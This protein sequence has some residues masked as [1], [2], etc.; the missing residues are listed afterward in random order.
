MFTI[1]SC[2]AIIT[3]HVAP[4]Y[5]RE[6]KFLTYRYARNGYAERKGSAGHYKF[7]NVIIFMV[8]YRAGPPK[9]RR[10]SSVKRSVGLRHGGGSVRVVVRPS[11]GAPA[12][13]Y[14]FFFNEPGAV[15]RLSGGAP[16][17]SL[18]L[19]RASAI[20]RTLAGLQ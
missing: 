18:C 14:K 16:A 2:T 19:F 17:R 13:H 11:S 7:F 5:V 1:L 3:S 20:D 6:N 4:Q 8:H 9:E 15:V 12:G 10:S